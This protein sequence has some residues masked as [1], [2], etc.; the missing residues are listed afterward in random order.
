MSDIVKKLRAGYGA[1]SKDVAD[2][3]ADEIERLRAEIERLR[4]AL[5]KIVAQQ[6]D[7]EEMTDIA[8]AALKQ[9]LRLRAARQAAAL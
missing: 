5:Q 9:L 1:I 3:A 8:R 6:H 7:H 2:A 4:A